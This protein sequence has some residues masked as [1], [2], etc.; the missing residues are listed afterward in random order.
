VG[1]PSKLRKKTVELQ[2][3]VRA[4]R[5]RR[6]PVPDKPSGLAAVDWGSREW[7]IRFAVAGV[8]FFALAITAVVID[9]G[10]VVSYLQ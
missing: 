5:I 4:S 9:L 8:I 7:E 2:T 3:E 10:Q 6:D 1:K